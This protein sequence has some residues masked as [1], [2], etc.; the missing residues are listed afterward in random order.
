MRKYF[1]ND[2][3]RLSKPIPNFKNFC[4]YFLI[5]REQIVYVGST[6]SLSIRMEDH[7]RNGKVFDKYFVINCKTKDESLELEKY[8]IK[9]INPYFNKT[10]CD[11]TKIDD[12]LDIFENAPTLVDDVLKY[13]KQ[14][15]EVKKY[16]DN[17]ELTKV[18]F[19]IPR[20]SYIKKNNSYYYFNIKGSIYYAKADLEEYILNGK[21][22]KPVGIFGSIES[23][24]SQT[25]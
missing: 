12:N 3:I 4:V 7:R 20:E 6:N 22:Y 10:H 25:F 9:S 23:I 11:R 2:I 18:T 19:K 21:I 5:Q 13:E 17:L 14:K 24:I 8:Y 1:K 15:V 16:V